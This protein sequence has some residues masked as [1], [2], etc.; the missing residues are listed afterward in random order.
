MLRLCSA[1]HFPRPRQLVRVSAQ[2]TQSALC[3]VHYDRLSSVQLLVL[4]PLPWCRSAVAPRCDCLAEWPDSH[5]HRLPRPRPGRASLGG[6]CGR[7]CP[8]GGGEEPEAHEEVS[9]CS[10]DT[11]TLQSSSQ[12]GHH[13]ASDQAWTASNQL[14]VDGLTGCR[15]A[16]LLS[17]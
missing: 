7:V 2:V 1:S 13:E 12:A 3:T 16:G 15:I 5:C 8:G 10:S 17:C 9:V 4:L 11:Q 14:L 6:Y